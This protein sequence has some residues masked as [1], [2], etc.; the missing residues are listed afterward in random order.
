MNKFFFT[1]FK[2]ISAIVSG[3]GLGKL[4]FAPKL[5]Q[6]LYKR[7]KPKGVV[8]VEAGGHTMFVDSHD[9]ALAPY[10][11]MHGNFDPEE[12]KILV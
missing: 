3:R 11:I 9:T 10:L 8:K 4:P 6:F 7:F 12:T 1:L 2:K 5:Y